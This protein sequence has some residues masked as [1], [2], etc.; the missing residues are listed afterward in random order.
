MKT[1]FYFVLWILIYPILGLLNNTFID[2]NAFLVAL[3]VVWGLSWLL[4]RLMPE[5]LSYERVSELVPIL[6]DVYT[7]NVPSFSKRLTRESSIAVVTAIYFAVTTIVIGIATFAIGINDWIA[8]IV[9]VIFTI[10]SIGKA[11]NLMKAKSSLNENPTKEHCVEIATEIYKLDYAF[12]Y[13]QRKDV[14]HKEML[15]QRP[16]H[17]KAFQ[18]FSLIIAAIAALL[19]LY[20]IISAILIIVRLSSFEAGAYAG[21]YFLYGSLAIYFG[22][23]DMISISQHLKKETH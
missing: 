17:F 18:I 6:E 12:Y 19:G 1:S 3:A 10:A 5:T 2:N 23:K 7:D 16:R 9:F 8:L 14:S 15:P 21:M 22:I 13:D 11:T 20:F 4:N